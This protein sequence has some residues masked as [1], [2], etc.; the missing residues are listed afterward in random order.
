[1]EWRTV[2][3]IFLPLTQWLLGQSPALPMTQ[4]RNKQQEMNMSAIF[5]CIFFFFKGVCLVQ[6]CPDP[7]L[8]GQDFCPTCQSFHLGS[9][10]LPGRTKSPVG[11]KSS[12]ILLLADGRGHFSC[13]RD[14]TQQ[15]GMQWQVPLA[16][17]Q[18]PFITN[19]FISLCFKRTV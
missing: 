2:L 18:Q 4:T 10:F 13:K 19:R 17:N 6:G 16:V 14:I 9:N 15:E 3:E 11:K 12:N 5:T 7:V 1:M 8:V